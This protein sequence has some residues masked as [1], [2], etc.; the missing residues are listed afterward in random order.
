MVP[1]IDDYAPHI[2]AV[3]GNL[4]SNDPRGHRDKRHIPYTVGDRNDRVRSSF[5]RAVETL[6]A[7]PQLRFTSAEV[8][9][10]LHV[11]ALRERFGIQE[12]DLELAAQWLDGAGVRWALDAVHRAELLG[13]EQAF[14]ENSWQ[15]GLNR[16]LLGYATGKSDDHAGILPYDEMTPA[17]A[18]LAARLAALIMQMKHWRVKLVAPARPSEWTDRLRKLVNE[19]LA[20]GGNEDAMARHQFDQALDELADATSHAELDEPLPLEVIRDTLL[21]ELDRHN[22]STR[23]LAGRV[24]FSTL[25]PMRAIPFRM[26]CLLGMNDGDYPRTRKPVDFD[27]MERFRRPGD[28]TRRDDD[29][30]LFL[31]ALL[32]ARDRLHIS[33]VGRSIRDNA[34]LPPSVLVGQ[35]QDALAAGWKLEESQSQLQSKSLIDHLTTKH[36]LQPFSREYFRPDQ[37]A[38]RTH[39]R[40]WGE[41]WQRTESIVQCVQPNGKTKPLTLHWPEGSIRLRELTEF[42]RQPVAFFMRRRMQVYLKNRGDIGSPPVD[43][44]FDL[45]PLQRW[46]LRDELLKRLML[47]ESDDDIEVVL[48]KHLQMVRLE[49]RLPLAESGQGL[50]RDAIEEAAAIGKRYFEECDRH[51]P[52]VEGVLVDLPFKIEQPSGQ[53]KIEDWL[54]DLRG[55]HSG[56]NTR[57]QL[58]ASKVGNGKSPRWDKLARFWPEHLAGC[59]MGQNLKTILVGEDQT[60]GFDPIMPEIAIDWLREL[61]ECWLVGQTRAL[62]VTPT[63]SGVWLKEIIEADQLDEEEKAK[64]ITKAIAKAREAYVGNRFKPGFL[65]R[66][67]ALARLYPDFDMLIGNDDD[68]FKP[69]SQRVYGAMVRTFLSQGKK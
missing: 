41:M 1:N 46:Q 47:E 4:G 67:P 40:E 52:L 11:P 42:Y 54:G 15:F 13:S 57:V 2:E 20:D 14:V 35:L 63:V 66:E 45:D 58:L 61:V 65:E 50:A 23:F 38:L 37:Q 21:E 3:F 64:A 30:Y 56:S 6:L 24:N 26:V 16:M 25:M 22:V 60:V 51:G 39:A 7:L 17:T 68:G 19:F 34:E 62:P 27:L 43:E 49:G 33:W 69:W 36:P 29:R 48:D 44:P 8:M 32:S 12:S 9:D 5:M 53:L 18:D 55:T 31:E 28:R 10:L 59:A